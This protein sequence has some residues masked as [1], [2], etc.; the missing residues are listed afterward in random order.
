MKIS[1]VA[2]AAG[3]VFV[4]CLRIGDRPTCKADVDCPLATTCEETTGVCVSVVPPVFV[5]ESF[6][7][8]DVPALDLLI[9]IE[10]RAT[11]CAEQAS[12]A[13]AFEKVADVLE[14]AEGPRPFDYRIAVVTTALD[15]STGGEFRSQV[16][17]D[18][19]CEG[20]AAED[21]CGDLFD[22]VTRDF[23]FDPILSPEVAG[24]GD[25]PAAERLTRLTT[26]LISAGT[27]SNGFGKGLEAMR[28][29]LSCDGPNSKRFGECCKGGVYDPL[30]APEVSPDFLRPDGILGVMFLADKDDCST[31]RDAPKH[32]GLAICKHGAD[33]EAAFEDPVLCA[34]KTPSE[35]RA[36]ECGDDDLEACYARRCDVDGT[37]DSTCIWRRDTALTPTNDYLGFLRSLKRNP[38][39][40]ITVASLVGPRTFVDDFEVS[41]NSVPVPAEDRA[42]Q[43]DR[44]GTCFS[45][46]EPDSDRS[47][48]S[49][50]CCPRGD[51]L[52]CI[53]P[54]CGSGP[55]LAYAGTRYL[56]LANA[57]GKNAVGCPPDRERGDECHSICDLDT[58]RF[59][60]AAAAAMV[61]FIPE[62]C[63]SHAPACKAD[64]PTCASAEGSGVEGRDVEGRIKCPDPVSDTAPDAEPDDM[65]AVMSDP[66][67]DA[68][69]EVF[70]SETCP[71]G[72]G[73]RPTKE[74]P[75]GSAI[76]LRYPKYVDPSLHR[77]AAVLKP[78]KIPDGDPQGVSSALTSATVGP[79]TRTLIEVDIR[80]SSRADLVVSLTHA[81]REVVLFRGEKENEDD[82][83][84]TFEVPDFVGLESGG[85]W[86]LS[87]T[88]PWPIDKGVL[89]TWALIVQL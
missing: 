87:V 42:Q 53:Q 29:A 23:T 80:H 5:A 38:D 51:C 16:A 52:G 32:A 57:F 78:L 49:P 13:Q 46:S 2:I 48:I 62:A 86:T 14:P 34:G 39:E 82:L 7:L 22:P 60:D 18:P 20:Q 36:A 88:D 83:R 1:L 15:S 27:G 77:F 64:S 40:Q 33:E 25:G 31:P 4:G 54:S 61:D 65:P 45:A 85:E 12:L 55:N 69:V 89:Q 11:M 66:C 76:V 19:S 6:F 35:C 58:T 72:F 21:S 24:V 59:V 10:D 63:L 28:R 81:G 44:V 3:L 30:C 67:A 68:A 71:S 73:A 9:V 17:L 41:Y 75:T 47:D 26:C 79:A 56:D 8:R 84:R 50:D 37:E 43:D 74:V 70:A